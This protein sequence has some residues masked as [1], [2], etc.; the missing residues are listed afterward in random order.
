MC[1]VWIAL[2]DTRKDSGELIIYPGSH[3]AP[4]LRAHELGLEKSED[5]SAYAKFEAAIAKTLE[6]EG[7]QRFV[8]M[9]KVGQIVVW[10]ENLIHGDS[11]RVDPNLTRR[12]IVSHYFAKGGIASYD[13]RA[14]A[15]TLEHVSDYQIT[16]AE[17]RNQREAP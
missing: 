4:R 8:Y 2:E 5:Y 11:R 16:P 14:E 6:S 12:S 10:H 17:V 1:G 9:P 3:R 15:A 13:S 7:F